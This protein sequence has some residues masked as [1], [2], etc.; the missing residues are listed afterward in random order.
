MLFNSYSFVLFLPAA[1]GLF[2]LM[3]KRVGVQNALIVLLSGYFY[4]CWDVRVLG[5]LVGS[6]VWTQAWMSILSRPKAKSRV[7]LLLAIVP[8][9]GILGVF[10]YYNFFVDSLLGRFAFA[11]NLHLDLI[12]PVGVS[13]YTFMCVSYLVDAYQGKFKAGLADHLNLSTTASLMFFPQLAAGPIGRVAAMVPQFREARHFDYA[14]AVEGC[15]QMLW[16]YFKKVLV[17]DTCS[18]VVAELL[19]SGQKSSVGIWV[20]VIVYT[21]QIYADFSGYSDLAIGCG[22]L[23]GIRL[24][25]NFSYPYFATNVGEFWRRWHMTLTRWLTDYIYIPLGGNR[26]S[27]GRRIFNTMVTFLTSGLWHG[28]AWN[29]VAWGGV[30]GVFFI[31]R[32]LKKKTVRC[33]PTPKIYT[34]FSWFLTMFVVALGWVLFR[35]PD[36][37]TAGHWYKMLFCPCCLDLHGAG[38]TT[39]GLGKALLFSVIMFGWEW[40]SRENELVRLPQARLFRWIIYLSGVL[41]FFGYFPQAENFIYFQF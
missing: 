20:G 14:Q 9:I 17:A 38:L 25:R 33:T 27:K 12:L 29:F 10:K 1:F 7:T 3:P 15:R 16:G 32:I 30:H 23:F 26:C 19:R 41:L 31:P 21:I 13:F 24:M 8:L 22:K 36:I 5:L 6:V 2:W 37:A 39:C 4:A 40:V 11:A 28:A 18:I 35:A 34:F